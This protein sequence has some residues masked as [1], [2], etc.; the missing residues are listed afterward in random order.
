MTG[1]RRMQGAWIAVVWGLVLVGSGGQAAPLTGAAERV[2]ALVNRERV[3]AGGAP[4]ASSPAL[5]AAAQGF[6]EYMAAAD[7]Y[8]HN[9]PDGS[10]PLG[11]MTAA[12]FP[13]T[14]AWGENIAVAYRDPEAVVGAWMASPGHRA[15]ILNPVF[16]HLGIGAAVSS[17][18]RWG[19]YWTLDFG[20]LAAGATETVPLRPASPPLVVSP[21]PPAPQPPVPQPPM[22]TSLSPMQGREGDTVALVGQNFGAVPGSVSFGGL[23][24]PLVS[25]SD[26]RVEVQVPNGAASGWVSLQNALGASGGVSFTVVPPPAPTPPAPL[27]FRLRLPTWS[28]LRWSA[29]GGVGGWLLR[30][31]RY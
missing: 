14:G 2:L 27:F 8:A 17:G 4:L 24:A 30:T 31:G 21:Q 12:G 11:R 26:T 3:Q 20:A 6:S 10:T 15:N 22:L 1:G 19:Y 23:T 28:A 13:G 5:D 25:W 29:P 7:F 16:T 18:S 9:G